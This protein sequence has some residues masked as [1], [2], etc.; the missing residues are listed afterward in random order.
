MPSQPVPADH[1]IVELSA[2][3]LSAAIQRR[4][5]SCTE[6]LQAFWGQIDRLNPQVNALVAPMPCE[7]LLPDR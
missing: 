7:P 5:L 3:A 6:V 2:V 1:S 4:E